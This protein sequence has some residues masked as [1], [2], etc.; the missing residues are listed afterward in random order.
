MIRRTFFALAGFALLAGCAGPAKP[1]VIAPQAVLATPGRLAGDADNDTRRK[2]AETLAF[3]QLQ[4]GMSVFELE[5]GGGYWTELL[6]SA[7]GPNGQVVMQNPAGF[8]PL[9]KETLDKRFTPGRLA[10][11]RRS[12][13]LFD[14]LDAPADAM[15]RVVWIQGPHDLYYM[16]GGASLGDPQKSFAEIA[17]ILKPG[18]ALIVIDH[19]AQPGAPTST[20]N[21]LHRIDPAVIAGLAT[22][23]GLTPAGAADFLANPTDPKT[24][25]VFDPAI[26]GRT[27]QFVVRFI[28]P[29]PR[30]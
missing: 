13:S 15:D 28:K 25:S 2:A 12:Q 3:M 21:D 14:V 27:D 9:V 11:V 5:A 24:Q 23:A 4:P 10:N 1:A 19:A 16:P 26:R 7:V 22:A 20:G 6:A 18:G 29:K 17:R 30:R 8:I